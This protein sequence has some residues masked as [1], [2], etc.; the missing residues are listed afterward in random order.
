MADL[1]RL[2]ANQ[3]QESINAGEL[4]LEEYVRALLA[5]IARRHAIKA[6]EYLDPDYVISQAKRLDALLPAESTLSAVNCFS[7]C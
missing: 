2:T 1:W 3:V 4:S 7:A 5:R 6:W